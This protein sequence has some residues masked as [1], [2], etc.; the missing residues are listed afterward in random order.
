MLRRPPR[1]T[2][3]DTLLPYTTLFRSELAPAAGAG[4][5]VAVAQ[6]L[7]LRVLRVPRRELRAPAPRR[8][9]PALEVHPLLPRPGGGGA[10]R[11]GE[12]SARDAQLRRRNGA[13]PADAAPARAAGGPAEPVRRQRTARPAD[14]VVS[15]GILHPPNG[16]VRGTPP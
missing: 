9:R 2:R 7:P 5:V 3:T 10:V 6:G 8:A 12:R 11:H 14:R 16:G 13:G 4:C 1:S 15:A